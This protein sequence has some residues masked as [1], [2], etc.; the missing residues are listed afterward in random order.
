MSGVSTVP[1]K[2]HHILVVAAAVVAVA[3]SCAAYTAVVV[4]GSSGDRQHGLASVGP[5]AS[6]RSVVLPGTGHT[7]LLVSAAVA[8]LQ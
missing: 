6:W 2:V 5:A 4:Q 3:A 8:V 7:A 1:S